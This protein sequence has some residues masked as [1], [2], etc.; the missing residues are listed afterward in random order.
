MVASKST[1]AQTFGAA[2]GSVNVTLERSRRSLDR[3]LKAFRVNTAH[4]GCH[5]KDR[6]F[7]ARRER[8]AIITELLGNDKVPSR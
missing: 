4:S 7:R 2:A 6:G 3:I 1:K 8:E 5:G